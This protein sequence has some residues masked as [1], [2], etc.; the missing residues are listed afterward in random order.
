MSRAAKENREEDLRLHDHGGKARRHADGK[1]CK[2]QPELGDAEEEAVADHIAPIGLG[3]RN[4][5]DCGKGCEEKAQRSQQQGRRGADPEFDHDEA[6]APEGG[7]EKG[8]EAMAERHLLRTGGPLS[9]NS[10]EGR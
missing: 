8:N 9:Q 10:K 6:Q 7:D 2:Q 5:E 3:P 4:E 1:R